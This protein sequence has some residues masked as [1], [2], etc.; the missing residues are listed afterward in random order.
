MT[1]FGSGPVLANHRVRGSRA[2]GGGRRRRGLRGHRRRHRVRRSRPLGERLLCWKQ[3]RG[4]SSEMDNAPAPRPGRPRPELSAMA[5]RST[6]APSSSAA[7]QCWEQGHLGRARRWQRRVEPP[8]RRRRARRRGGRARRRPAHRR[9][10]RD[11]AVRRPRRRVARMPG[12]GPPRTARTRGPGLLPRAVPA[13]ALPPPHRRSPRPG[14]RRVPSPPTTRSSAGEAPSSATTPRPRASA[15]RLSTMGAPLGA[16]PIS[17]PKPPSTTGLRYAQRRAPPPTPRRRWGLRSAQR[18]APP[19]NPRRR[20]GERGDGLPRR[21][22]GRAPTA[23]S[24]AAPR[25]AAAIAR[26]RGSRSPG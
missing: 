23:P 5:S 8:G 26:R 21:V 11:L 13:A 15:S 7:V 1:T 19:P 12:R 9:R 22:R 18:R 10:Q 2:R 24:P 20:R 17:A 16:A 14:T 3:Y 6:R 4:A 25:W